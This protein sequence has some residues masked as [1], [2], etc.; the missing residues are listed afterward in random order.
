MSE[1]A[2][3]ACCENCGTALQGAYC[4]LCGQSV[5]N[6]IRHAGHALEEVFESF[7]H[8]DGRVFRTVRDLVVPGR[9]AAN[10]IAG[11]R[12]RYIAPL[13][14]FVVLTLLT[15]FIGQFTV[16]FG[17]GAIQLDTDGSGVSG[18]GVDAELAQSIN[19]AQTPAKVE[20]LR[21]DALA[22]LEQARAQVE[23]LPIPGPEP[24]LLA[25]SIAING[26][27]GN[28]IAQLRREAASGV[29][30]GAGAAAKPTAT[31]AVAAAAPPTAGATSAEAAGS[32][33]GGPDQGFG[34]VSFNGQPWDPVANPLTVSWWP[35]YANAWLNRLV[36]R[37]KDNLPRIRQDPEL[38]KQ[39]LMGAVPSALLVLVPVFALLLKLGYIGTGRGY[40]EHL[41]VALYS[42]AFLVLGLLAM[43]VL[44]G[45]SRWFAPQAG[46]AGTLIGLA[47]GL[48]W[49]WMAIYL[50]LMQ[51]RVYRQGWPM[52]AFKYFLMGNLYLV[53]VVTAAVFV[54][55]A[56]LVGA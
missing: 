55:A 19:R 39:A 5:H 12:A 8:L 54:V 37:G 11:H 52:T 2:A 18:P 43:F 3:P 44:V 33:P 25:A 16:V 13:R 20:R 56:G 21:D 42:H 45:L 35:D 51:K 47:E 40:L 10:Y 29:T 50:L 49:C 7:W 15:F 46:A 48:L 9:V 53:L 34:T 26:M 28:R 31:P 27:A 32:S 23:G 36:A 24:A 6:P 41:V 22:E 14:L 30:A 38:F 17:P 4:H 1:R